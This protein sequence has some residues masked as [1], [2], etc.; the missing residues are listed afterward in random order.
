MKRFLIVLFLSLSGL[1]SFAQQTSKVPL[2]DTTANAK[3][4]IK[5]AV[6]LAAK[7]HKNVMLQIGGNWCIWCTRFH[8]TVSSNDTLSKLMRDNYIV[9]HV[10]YEKKNSENVLWKELGYPQRFGFPVFVILDEKGNRIHTQNSAYLEEGKGHSPAKIAEF[11]EQWS[12]AAL[13]GATLRN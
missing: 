3:A 10:N 6:A 12:P 9:V 1:A 7:E 11:L 13:R 4:D 8:N 2:Y 5:K